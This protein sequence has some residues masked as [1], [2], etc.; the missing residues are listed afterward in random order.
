VGGD[1]VIPHV[2]TAHRRGAQDRF[3]S[4][5][6]HSPLAPQTRRALPSLPK[7]WGGGADFFCPSQAK[8]SPAAIATA[9]QAVTAGLLMREQAHMSLLRS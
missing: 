7:E 6:R 5:P 2:P 4:L 1:L 8:R 3:A 9:N